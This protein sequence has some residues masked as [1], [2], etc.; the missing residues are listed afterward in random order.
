MSHDIQDIE[1]ITAM[2]LKRPNWVKDP[3]TNYQSSMMLLQYPGSIG[4]LW[5]ENIIVPHKLIFSFR[6]KTKAEEKIALDFFE[7][8][9]GRHKNFWMPSWVTEFTVTQDINYRDT[10]IYVNNDFFLKTYRGHERIAIILNSGDIIVRQIDD[11]TTYQNIQQQRDEECLTLSSAVGRNIAITDIELC[12]FFLLV[13]FDKDVM[14][15]DYITDSVSDCTI[16]TYELIR[17]YP[18]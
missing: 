12:C 7:A 14:A 10:V 17:E 5:V 9:L 3:S 2:L 8:Q 1:P 16:S 18:L 4:G 13:R 15:L 11:V 6:N